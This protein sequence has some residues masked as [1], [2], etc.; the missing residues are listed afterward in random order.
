M[1]EKEAV[2]WVKKIALKQKRHQ[3][4]LCG[5][6]CKLSRRIGYSL[7]LPN[8]IS[9]SFYADHNGENVWISKTVFL[10]CR[11]LQTRFKKHTKLATIP[12]LTLVLSELEFC[13]LARIATL[14]MRFVQNEVRNLR[15]IKFCHECLRHEVGFCS[16]GSGEPL[17]S[18]GKTNKLLEDSEQKTKLFSDTK[19]NCSFGYSISHH[20]VCWGWFTLPL[21][22][23]GHSILHI[24]C[25]QKP[26]VSTKGRLQFYLNLIFC[27]LL[28]I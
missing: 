21:S 9:C 23:K 20:V 27:L 3:R 14:C 6:E 28:S 13:S 8:L 12:R 24:T 10:A 7:S 18:K 4:F 5:N 17:Q 16:G 2:S 1:F 22:K 25:K 19:Y 26:W 15:G 11:N